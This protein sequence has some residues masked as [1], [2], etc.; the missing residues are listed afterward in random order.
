MTSGPKTLGV[1]SA[2]STAEPKPL[3]IKLSNDL[4][5]VLRKFDIFEPE[6]ELNERI[7]VL[8]QLNSL[9]KQWIIDLSI[10]R[11]IS[12]GIAEQ[13]GGKI[14]TFG[15]Y[16]LGV[17]TRGADID[18][19]LVAPRHIDRVDFF[20][21]FF[22]VLQSHPNVTDL[23]AIE[24][25][26]VP[27][28]KFHFKGI[29]ID[30]L[31]ARLALQSIPDNLTLGDVDLLKNLDYKCV[32][33][34]NGCRVT[35]DILNLVPKA[36]SFRLALRAIKLWAKRRGTYSNSLGFLGGVSWAI[37]MARVCQLYPKAAPATLVQKFF[38]VFDQWK[39]PTPVML[40][41]PEDIPSANL[42]FPV[43]DSRNNPSDRAHLMPILTP[44][45][46][47]QNSTFNVTVS[48]KNV[49]A[50][51]FKIGLGVCED[52]FSGKTDWNSLF[53]PS[54]FFHRYKHYI[55][56]QA[57]GA[58]NKEHLEWVGLVES[59][60][61]HLVGNLERFLCIESAHINPTGY[62]HVDKEL[63]PFTTQWLI[64]LSIVR[65]SDSNQPINLDLTEPIQRF[66]SVVYQAA[67]NN[68]KVTES[69][70]VKAHHVKKRQL[71]E[72]VSPAI[73]KQ[74]RKRSKKS[75][76][77]L[78]DGSN[79]TLGSSFNDS[80]KSVNTS[81]TVVVPVERGEKRLS[82]VQSHE[83]AKKPRSDSE[84]STTRDVSRDT[85]NVHKNEDARGRPDNQCFS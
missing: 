80:I 76:L 25:A 70:Q 41:H 14:F 57:M 68:A 73:L 75:S 33:S 40:R 38:L 37:L 74:G 13:V 50:Q 20:S 82:E 63:Y 11:N 8:Q 18:T 6:N 59:K 4:E 12:R 60:I 1:T 54:D 47:Q 27:V 15:S 22:E 5:D 62:S 42:P 84:N 28:M 39:W 79:T 69:M 65:P 31:F 58:D 10:Q 77:S 24:E 49:M 81:S 2:I 43:W 23:R 66:V 61:R 16:R 29:E 17:H 83:P 30:L 51:E 35:E 32:K 64:G 19:L 53:E 78:L 26:Y 71:S 21:T 7:N 55:I 72:Y 56:I 36:E 3:D 9:A 67:A 52:V 34:L 46:P 48:T 45:F 85:E 44:T